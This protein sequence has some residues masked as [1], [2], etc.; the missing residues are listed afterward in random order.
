M[1]L[2][3]KMNMNKIVIDGVTYNSVDEMPPEVRRNYEEAMR[4]FSAATANP[5]NPIQTLNNVFSDTNNNGM[6]DI[7]ENQA[8]NFPSGMKF[9]VNG[10]TFNKLE[11]LPPEARARYEQ[12]MG[13]LDKNQNGVP[14]FM[15][16]V[17]RNV[18]QGQSQPAM[19]ATSQPTFDT[20][21]RASR[22]PLPASPTIAPDTSNGW[23]LALGAL[24]VLLVC[25]L[26]ALGVWYFFIR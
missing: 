3:I 9:V 19:T 8:L 26:G 18:A 7:V 22:A 15:E 17:M 12:V 25:S 13:T 6:P 5:A 11:D 23:A 14:D 20:T 24:F 2:E 4:G 16:G 1:E 21:R 10:Q